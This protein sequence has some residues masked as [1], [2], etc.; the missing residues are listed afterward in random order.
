MLWDRCGAASPDDNALTCILEDGHNGD[1]ASG[2]GATWEKA[3]EPDTRSQFQRLIDLRSGAD[4]PKWAK[5]VF[6]ARHTVNLSFWDRLKVLFGWSLEVHTATALEFPIGREETRSCVHLFKPA[7]LVRCHRRHGDMQAFAG[8]VFSQEPARKNHV[9]IC[10]VHGPVYG[11][12]MADW[13]PFQT[14]PLAGKKAQRNCRFCAGEGMID[15]DT[16]A[17]IRREQESTER[18]IEESEEHGI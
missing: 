8:E 3:P 12:D 4:M 13:R 9:C 15:L 1:H 18:L 5:D 6:T 10:V 14:G 16:A 17:A 7:W 2:T 11:I